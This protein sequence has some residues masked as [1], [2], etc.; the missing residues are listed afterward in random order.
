MNI[1]NIIKQDTKIGQFCRF[2]LVGG[3]ATV[4]HYAI[5]LIIH[6]FGVPLN[7]AYTLGY[8]LSF[9]FNY[10]ASN[11][12]TFNAKPN[13]Q[14]GIKFIGAHCCN[15]VVQMLLLNI[16]IYLGVPQFIAPI[17]VFVIAI[18]V[19]F[20]LVRIAFKTSNRKNNDRSLDI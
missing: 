20:I 17:G 18:P 6:A 5:Y 4:L 3:I 1:I 10:I 9:I 15:Y 14:S 13:A 2:V 19:N 7:M 8:G 12:F 16:Y 11:Y